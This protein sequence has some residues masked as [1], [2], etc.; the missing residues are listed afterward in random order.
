MLYFNNESHVQTIA[1][2]SKLVLALK[3]LGLIMLTVTPLPAFDD[4]YI[5]A[6]QVPNIDGAYVV[7]PGDAD[8]V[9]KFLSDKQIPLLGVLIT[10]HHHDHTGGIAKLLSYY[11]SNTPV[12]GPSLEN[13]EGVNN[14]LQACASITL[15][16]IDLKAE[17]IEVPGH[18]LGHIAYV[19]ED[20]LFCGDTLFSAGCGR[21]FEGTPQQMLTSLT[22]LAQVGDDKKV[23]CTHEYTLANLHFANRVDPNNVQ[24]QQYTHHSEQLRASNTPT[25]PSSIAQERAINPFLRSHSTEIQQSL[26]EQFQ[27]PINDAV[28]CF[29]LLRQWKD[30]F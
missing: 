10:H 18:T 12:Y 14:P 25:L 30:N 15:Q 8:V 6:I 13:I 1:I 2:L 4:N 19:I 17:V 29:A 11:G 27:Q 23:Y 21:L 26:A 16:G 9:I 5:W 3:L 24:L 20:A 28:K 7:D 22:R